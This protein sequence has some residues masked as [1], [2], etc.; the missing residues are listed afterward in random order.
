MRILLAHNYYQR[1]GGE[2]AVFE[3]E[4]EL[5]EQRGHTVIRYVANNKSIETF[6]DKALTF[7]RAFWNTDAARDL[8]AV[9]ERERP[10]ILH[11]HNFFPLLSPSIYDA[12]RRGGV[13]VVQTLHNYR[14]G[15]ASGFLTRDGETC[16]LCIGK[17]PFNAV[18]HRCYRGSLPGSV[19]VAG[20]IAAHAMRGTWR[21][22]VDRFIAL[23]EFSRGKLIEI[24]VPDAKIMVKPNFVPDRGSAVGGVREGAL[25]VGRVS[26]EKGILGLVEAWRADAAKLTIAGSGPL[27]E[28]VR[29]AAG[30]SVTCLGQLAADQLNVEYRRAQFVVLPSTA[31][32]SMPMTLLEAWSCSLPVIAFRH[33]AFAEMIEDG[34]TGLLAPACDFAALM[35]KIR[36][37]KAN[38]DAVAA[39]GRAGRRQYEARF[40]PDANY[41]QLMAVYRAAREAT[42]AR[43][44][45]APAASGYAK[46]N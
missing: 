24:G 6:V 39:M 40:T 15:C 13:P 7:K 16:E 45:V 44:E 12:A 9:M 41:E 26:S 30:P 21:T 10:D 20:M 3:N 5:L 25:F 36:W 46:Q 31:F 4:A 33:S 11:T 32:E 14:L 8:G 1:R 23:T 19:A 27:D 42:N 22:K 29:S 34:V 43:S 18:R 37:A 35:D 17:L 28:A 38:P 2:D